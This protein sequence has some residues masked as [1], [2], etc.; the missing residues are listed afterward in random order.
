MGDKGYFSG[1]GRDLPLDVSLLC[2]AQ[3]EAQLPQGCRETG[4]ALCD[5]CWAAYE[6]DPRGLK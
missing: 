3:K 5:W 4:S 1:Q 2:Q 6:M